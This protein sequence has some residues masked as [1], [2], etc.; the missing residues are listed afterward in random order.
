MG[1]YY[2][3]VIWRRVI[4]R[5]LFVINPE[6]SELGEF[7]NRALLQFATLLLGI[8][9]FIGVLGSEAYLRDGITGRKNQLWPRFLRLAIPLVGFCILGVITFRVALAMSL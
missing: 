6:G 3:L 7:S 8:F 2:A 4:P 1:A 5:L 9:L